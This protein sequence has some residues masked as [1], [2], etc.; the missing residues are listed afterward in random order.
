MDYTDD[1]LIQTTGG[2][3]RAR[4][5]KVATLL[6]W[7]PW[8]SFFVV[9]IPLP[10]VFLLF[11]LTSAA[12]DSAAIYLLLSFVSLGVGLVAGLFVLILLLLYRKRWH[13]RLREQLAAD[14]VTADEVI[15]FRS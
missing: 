15:W 7:A 5:E 2:K 13:S 4:D 9:A 1:S 10:I 8:L 6:R 12:T 3:I 14:G 11:F